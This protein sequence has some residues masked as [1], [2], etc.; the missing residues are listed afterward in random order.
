MRSGPQ[1]LLQVADQVI[2]VFK[3]DRQP[4]HAVSHAHFIAR[5]LADLRG[6]GLYDSSL[7][8]VT[9]DHGEALDEHGH[10]RHVINLYDEL[11]H[12]PLMIKPPAGSP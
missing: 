11:L 9:S 12:V 6:R 1:R 8:V 10:T 4:H 7:I 2:G 3:P 5:L